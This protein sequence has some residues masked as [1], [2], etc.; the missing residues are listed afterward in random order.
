MPKRGRGSDQRGGLNPVTP[1]DVSVV[2]RT[3]PC[4]SVRLGAASCRTPRDPCMQA[5]R[6]GGEGARW[7][8]KGFLNRASQVR[9]L[10]GAP[11]KWCRFNRLGSGLLVGYLTKRVLSGPPGTALPALTL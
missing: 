8:W 2:A 7:A 3:A 9:V 6:T 1:G 4:R 5:F 11:A 10:P